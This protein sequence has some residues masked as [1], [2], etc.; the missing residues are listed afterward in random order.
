MGTR[1]KKIVCLLLFFVFPACDKFEMRG[2]I[3]SYESP[4]ERFEQS[5]DW[6]NENPFTEITVTTDD[7]TIFVMADSHLGGTENLDYFFDEAIGNGAVAAV[8]AGDLTSGH[9]EDYF[10]FNQ[11][12]PDKTTLLTFPM[13]G[14][15]DLFFG[16]WLQFNSVFGSTT[17]L[18]SVTTP[19]ASDL[20]ICLDSGSATLGNRQLKWL[21]N[22]LETERQNY[23]YC[24]LFTH[25]NLF[26][27]RHTSS[28]NPFVEELQVLMELCVKYQINMVIAGH[29]HLK[30]T[31]KFGNTTHITL[32]A[33]LD[34][35]EDAGY[36]T[37]S[38]NQGIIEYEF[39][40]L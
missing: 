38:V 2:F 12:R 24:I 30:N 34:G 19:Q 39:I 22:I 31:V 16:G 8:M 36:L 15:H 1:V 14:N 7:Y 17:Y 33:L 23:R 29:D 18:F 40:N 27:I 25:N 20:Y 21:K 9:K 10:T 32:D 11:H 26:R 4:D 5:M 6:N 35:F 13:V 28:A 37:L 3:L